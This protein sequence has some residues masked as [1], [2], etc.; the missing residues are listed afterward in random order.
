MSHMK[1]VQRNVYFAV[2]FGCNLWLSECVKLFI[3]RELVIVCFA[4]LLQ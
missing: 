3:V 1:K 2:V 4:Y